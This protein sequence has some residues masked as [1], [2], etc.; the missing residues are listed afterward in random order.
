MSHLEVGAVS[1]VLAMKEVKDN[2]GKSILDLKTFKQSQQEIIRRIVD[3]EYE[4]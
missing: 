1:Q 2:L 3:S 4:Y